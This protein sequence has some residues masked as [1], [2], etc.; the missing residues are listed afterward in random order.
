MISVLS[1]VGGGDVYFIFPKLSKLQGGDRKGDE[2]R[3]LS[4]VAGLSKKKKKLLNL[5]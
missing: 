5:V 4:W 3:S 2:D 1:S